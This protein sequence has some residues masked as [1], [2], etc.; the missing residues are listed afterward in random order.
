MPAFKLN[1]QGKREGQRNAITLDAS[2]GEDRLRAD[3]STEGPLAELRGLV[4]QANAK[5]TRLG[6]FF[7]LLGLTD[8]P[9]PAYSLDA[10]VGREGEAGARVDVKASLGST[11]ADI[12]G[13]IGD[14]R[15]FQGLDLEVVMSGQNPSDILDIFGLPEISLPPY[16]VA[17]RLGRQGDVIRVANLDGRVGDSDVA[18]TASVDTGR[19]PVAVVADLASEKLDFDDLAGLIGLPPSTGAGE[20]ASPQQKQEAQAQEESSRLLPDVKIDAQAW[21]NLDLDIRYRGRSVEAP[22]LPLRN[23]AFH[24]VTREG[25]LTLDPLQ[26]SL[27]GGRFIANA[28]LDGTGSAVNGDFDVRVRGLQL[29]DFLSRFGFQNDALGMLG[30]RAELKGRG[31]SLRELAAT[32][33]GRLA[34]TMEGGVIDRLIPELAGLDLSQSLGNWWQEKFGGKKDANRQQIRCLIADFD[35]RGGVMDAKTVLLDTPEDKMTVQGTIDLRD[36]QLDL[37]FHAFPRD[38]SI[39]SSR[40]PISIEGPIKSPTVGPAP[41]YVENQTLGWILA[42]LAALIPFVELGAED[43]HPCAGVLERVREATRQP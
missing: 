28:S 37:M 27:A 7:P 15:A 3:A 20:A 26:A 36:E 21:R 29:N 18:G 35:V 4:L 19:K 8:K 42:P 5:G 31:A 22:R 13:L 23:L 11:K 1:A 39:G 12:E 24:V 14:V 30:G 10:K 38:A 6:Q 40:M 34:L 32:S 9:V 33:D 17:G 43:D 2:F 41:G 25:W 16:R